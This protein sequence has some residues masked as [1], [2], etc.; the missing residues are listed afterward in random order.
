MGNTSDSR[1]YDQPSY[2]IETNGS[3][4]VNCCVPSP[5]GKY[6]AIGFG[7]K[8]VRLYDYHR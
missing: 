3:D 6:I 5:D 4:T 8:T 1:P 7:K 2:A